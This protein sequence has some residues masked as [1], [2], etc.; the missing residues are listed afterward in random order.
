MVIKARLAVFVRTMAPMITMPSTPVARLTQLRRRR[1][2]VNM[3]NG[4]ADYVG[5]RP[6]GDP[7]LDLAFIDH[8]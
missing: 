7:R 8:R 4:N 3:T 5:R 6:S 2:A 1:A